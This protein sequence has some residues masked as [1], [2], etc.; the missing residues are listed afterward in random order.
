MLEREPQMAARIWQFLP[1]EPMAACFR[2]F[3]T[4]NLFCYA[5]DDLIQ[6]DR[7]FYKTHSTRACLTKKYNRRKL[8]FQITIAQ[9]S[10][11][12]CVACRWT[13][14]LGRWGFRSRKT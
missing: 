8:F 7:A 11:R 4:A 3:C 10:L 12:R 14:L 2:G 13:V 6:F 9:N 5:R 1:P